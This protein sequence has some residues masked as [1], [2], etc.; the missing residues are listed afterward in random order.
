MPPATASAATLRDSIYGAPTEGG[1]EIF[2][3][4]LFTH[5]SQVSILA[6]ALGFA[7]GIPTMILAVQNGAST[8]AMFAAFAPH[9]LGWGFFAWLM[10]HGTTEIMAIALAAAAGIH[11]GRAVAFP[12][13][14][15]RMAAAQEAGR[16]GAIVMIGVFLMLL[17]AGL[18]EGFGRQLIRDDTARLAIGGTMLM[19]WTLYF[20]FG[21]RRGPA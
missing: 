7:F 21:G 4:S 1:L 19:I 2:A 5:N 16:R 18:L 12:G 14:R 15:T 6:F 11:I 13:E 9:G 10:I 17:V 8:G 20:T 3:T